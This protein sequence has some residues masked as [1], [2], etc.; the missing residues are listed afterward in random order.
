MA[1]YCDTIFGDLLGKEVL[2]DYP[3]SNKDAEMS[4]LYTI[5]LRVRGDRNIYLLLNQV[6]SSNL[7]F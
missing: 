2:K 5:T 1:K 3:V 7:M 4:Q 6:D